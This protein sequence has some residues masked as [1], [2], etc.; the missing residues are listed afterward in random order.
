M[1]A[2]SMSTARRAEVP[3][4]MDAFSERVLSGSFGPRNDFDGLP[5]IEDIVDEVLRTWEISEAND[6]RARALRMC[7]PRPDAQ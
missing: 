5:L 6:V 3:R 4:F 2:D 7:N 1:T